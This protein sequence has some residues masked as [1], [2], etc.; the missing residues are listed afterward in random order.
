[1]DWLR[2]ITPPFLIPI[3]L[4]FNNFDLFIFQIDTISIGCLCCSPT[5]SYRLKS[6]LISYLLQLQ[7]PIYKQ[8]S[9]KDRKCLSKVMG[10]HEPP[11]QLQCT[12]TH[13][14]QLSG[15]VLEG[16]TTVV[17]KDISS[18]FWWWWWRVDQEIFVQIQ[19]DWTALVEFWQ[20]FLN[21]CC[22]LIRSNF[23]FGFPSYS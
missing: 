6:V 16:W 14:L 22:F 21:V 9:D 15:T 19:W 23:T 3:Q 11:G 13:T 7:Y 10:S 17:P 2:F 12:L 18:V 5:S 4:V 1:M 20:N 8:I